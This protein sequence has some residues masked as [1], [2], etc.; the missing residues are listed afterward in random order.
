MKGINEDIIAIIDL[1]NTPIMRYRHA[2]NN[3]ALLSLQSIISQFNAIKK[4][5]KP[6][7][8]KAIHF[9]MHY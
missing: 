9:L 7:W 3:S 2:E 6:A 5:S 1:Y 4:G 8:I